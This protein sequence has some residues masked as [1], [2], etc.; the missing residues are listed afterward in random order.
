MSDT[1]THSVVGG[2]P[3]EAVV[4]KYKRHFVP[5][6]C[7]HCE[8]VRDSLLSE[9]FTPSR[10][11]D[12]D[13]DVDD[14]CIDTCFKHNAASW[15][16]SLERRFDKG[17]AAAAGSKRSGVLD[18]AF[19]NSNSLLVEPTINS[20]HRTPPARLRYAHGASPYA[21]LPSSLDQDSARSKQQGKTRHRN[22]PQ[23]AYAFKSYDVQAQPKHSATDGV[24]QEGHGV[25][26]E[27]FYNRHH[28]AERS[29]MTSRSSPRHHSSLVGLG[30]FQHYHDVSMH[31]RDYKLR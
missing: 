11:D 27:R 29:P 16:N 3:F 8:Q 21:S 15:K 1:I 20:T 23:V 4:Y 5:R 24:G 25:I 7:D 13:N 14:F 30:D 10:N 9:S 28:N 26:L 6:K 18:V 17:G 19:R 31:L 22:H 12:Y 2:V